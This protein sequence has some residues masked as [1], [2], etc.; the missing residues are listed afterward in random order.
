[1]SRNPVD[2]R[3]AA[4]KAK[5]FNDVVFVNWSLSAEEKAS[6]KAWLINLE[7]LDD[8]LLKLVEGGY[9]TTL[10]WDTYRECFTASIV[11]TEDSD[12]NKGYILTGK[13]STPLKAVKQACYIHWHVMD[14]NWSSYAKQAEREELDD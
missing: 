2:K 10:S 1:M 6:C 14:G 4:P 7:D 12:P 3:K 8:A 13:G 11:P 5:R 9:K